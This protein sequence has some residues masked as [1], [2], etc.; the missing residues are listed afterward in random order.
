MQGHLSG[1]SGEQSGGRDQE[2]GV[3]KCR[4][5]S[6]LEG[7]HTNDMCSTVADKKSGGK[8]SQVC[9]RA[10]AQECV[11]RLVCANLHS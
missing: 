2:M 9:V 8:S 4:S 10:T 6:V 11:P 1:N 3:S 7:R 5:V